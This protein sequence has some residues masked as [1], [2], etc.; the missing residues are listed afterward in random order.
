MQ[1]LQTTY[2]QSATVPQTT[3]VF[4]VNQFTNNFTT[5]TQK[6]TTYN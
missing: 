4:S 6:V 5:Y 3:H 2:T 1:S